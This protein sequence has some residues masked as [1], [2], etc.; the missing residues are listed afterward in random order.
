MA[1]ELAGTSASGYQKTSAPK[2][3]ILIS[4]KLVMVRRKLAIFGA[5]ATAFVVANYALLLNTHAEQDNCTFGP[6]SNEQYRAHLGRAKTHLTYAFY[7]D[8]RALA[9]KLDQLFEN[10]S[11]GESDIYSRIA[12]MH[13]TLR[14]IGAEYRNTNG[15][16]V[17][18]GRSDPYV[19]TT[20]NSTTVSFNYVL[21]VNRLWIFLP[22]PREAWII[23][24]L[25]GPRYKEPPGPSYPK[26][27]GGIAFIV[28]G[29]NLKDTPF[30]PDIRSDAPCPPLPSADLADS[31]SFAS[32]RGITMRTGEQLR[33]E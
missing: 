12:I 3:S 26:K 29:P 7:S 32:T 13:A 33:A 1:S 16:H 23:G 2:R 8:D 17:D 18:Q 4:G 31:F 5:I 21:D 19:K 27:R 14:A 20:T 10:L 24:S 6:V 15:N 9:L 28:N 25:A 22:W 30:G 11:R